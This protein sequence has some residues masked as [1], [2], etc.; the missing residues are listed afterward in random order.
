MVTLPA[1][2]ELLRFGMW[3]LFQPY[4][5]GIGG[6]EEAEGVRWGPRL[7]RSTGGSPRGGRRG[8]TQVVPV[9]EQRMGKLGH[10]RLG[11]ELKHPPG[12][13]LGPRKCSHRKS[14]PFR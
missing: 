10:A 1:S 8:H 11:G 7:Q 13:R 3:Y 9:W 2:P 6:E 5:Q 12:A 4:W 14:G